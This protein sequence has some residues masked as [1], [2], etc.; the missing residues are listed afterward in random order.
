MNI[1]KMGYQPNF[2]AKFVKNSTIMDFCKDEINNGRDE[3]LTHALK[4]LSKHHSNVALLLSKSKLGSQYYTVTNLYN[5]NQIN[6]G[7]MSAE[8][9][10][11]LNDIHSHEYKR[12][13][14]GEKTITPS[15]TNSMVNMISEKYMI[16]NSPD[17]TIGHLVDT[18]I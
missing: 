15:K 16:N 2:Q 13:F 10:D 3:E 4:K 8:S 14:V 7:A 18:S 12:L 9:L 5:G 17:Y 6:M 11:K 1:Q